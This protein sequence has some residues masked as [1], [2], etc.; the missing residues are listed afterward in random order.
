[1]H[2]EAQLNQLPHRIARLYQCGSSVCSYRSAFKDTAGHLE[3]EEFRR[4]LSFNERRPHDVSVKS[5]FFSAVVIA[6]LFEK[7]WQ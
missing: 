6:F 7:L 4:T 1:M 3:N 5:H 2:A